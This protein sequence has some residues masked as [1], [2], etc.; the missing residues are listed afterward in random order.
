MD[1]AHLTAL[2]WGLPSIRTILFSCPL[3]TE[4]CI[5]PPSK[6]STWSF[7]SFLMDIYLG[8]WCESWEQR[9]KLPYLTSQNLSVGD[10]IQTNLLQGGMVWHLCFRQNFK[11]IYFSVKKKKKSQLRAS[12]HR[13]M[14]MKEKIKNRK[15][16]YRYKPT[17]RIYE[18]WEG[19]P[20]RGP[21]SSSPI[22]LSHSQ[23]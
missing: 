23:N 20:F 6:A 3:G 7:G 8:Y 4:S 9:K 22:F 2:S 5:S 14:G 15:S 21:S 1:F 13:N 19:L 17:F 18:I 10:K 16:I 12:F 11:F